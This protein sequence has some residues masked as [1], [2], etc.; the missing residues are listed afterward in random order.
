MAKKKEVLLVKDVLKVGNM[1]DL[2]RVAPGFARN[3]LFPYGLAV[4]AEGA[5]KRQIEVLR[6][7]AAKAESEREAKAVQLKQKMLGLKLSLKARVS[8]DDVLFGSIGTKELVAALAAV[9]YQVDSKQIHLHDK[10]R[11]LGTFTVE[12]RLHKNVP[13]EVQVEIVNADPNAPTLAER[14]AAREA[15]AKA[16]AEAKA[17]ADE[18]PAEGEEK[19]KK[20]KKADK[21]EKPAKAEKAAKTDKKKG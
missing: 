12:V 10:L 17:A 2:V 5:A 7:K 3:Y 11:K 8:H 4:S 6:E 15:R 21:A 14:I 19:D 18:A 9:G 1:G 16:D 20:G 13:V